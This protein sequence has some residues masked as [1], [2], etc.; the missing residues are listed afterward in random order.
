M[1]ARRP[2]RINP[3]RAVL[4]PEVADAPTQRALD[5]VSSAVSDLQGARAR[6]RVVVDLVVGVNRIRHGLGRPHDGYALVARGANAAFAHGLATETNPR[7]DREIWIE[8]VGSSMS[9][10]IVE[11]W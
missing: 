11:V 2:V 3:G 6:D 5:A 1:A 10:A 7:P 8:V 9:G 4:V